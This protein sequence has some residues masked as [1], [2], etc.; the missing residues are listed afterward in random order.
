MGLYVVKQI[1]EAH[2]G[3]ID[4]QSEFGHG[5]TFRVR[6]PLAVR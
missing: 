6:L 2:D 3:R 4:V 5:A 1:V